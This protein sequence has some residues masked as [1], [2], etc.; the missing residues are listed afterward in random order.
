MQVHGCGRALPRCRPAEGLRDGAELGDAARRGCPG[1]TAAPCHAGSGTARTASWPAPGT[2][3]APCREHSCKWHLPEG[4]PGIRLPTSP[5]TF[6]AAHGNRAS[7]NPILMYFKSAPCFPQ[8]PALHTPTAA[9]PRSSQQ[10]T[11]FLCYSG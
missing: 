10:M 2:A 9:A 6:P 8:Q 1:H 5:G 3:R 4:T 11:L 7:Q